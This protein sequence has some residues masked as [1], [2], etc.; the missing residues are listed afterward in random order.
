MGPKAKAKAKANMNTK[1]P[2][3][4]SWQEVAKEAQNHRDETISQV[5]PSVPKISPT[6]FRNIFDASQEL[7]SSREIN[8]TSKS[9]EEILHIIA[10]KEATCTEVC[11]AFLRRA[12]VA[13][14]LVRNIFVIC[15]SSRQGEAHKSF[16]RTAS[17][18]SCLSKLCPV[19]KNLIPLHFPKALSMAFQ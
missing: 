10:N 12:A 19:P 8:L 16:R 9:P 7:L 17:Q 14:G 5:R 18:N 11:N 13:Q 15:T 1:E 2:A 3:K 6:K 4:R